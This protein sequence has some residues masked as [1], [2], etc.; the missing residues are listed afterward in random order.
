[1][2]GQ[3]RLENKLIEILK[4]CQ[5]LTLSTPSYA[6]QFKFEFLYTIQQAAYKIDGKPNVRGIFSYLI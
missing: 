3:Y 6:S 2:P 1:M 5:N 4:W